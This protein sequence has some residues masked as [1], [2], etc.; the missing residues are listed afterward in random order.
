MELRNLR[1]FIAVAQEL[2][3]GR[4]AAR[5]H[6]SQ[7][8]LSERIKRLEQELGVTLF[9]RTKRSVRITAAGTALFLEAQR[10]L[11]D[12]EGLYQVVRRANEGITGIIRA[13]FMS[14]ASYAGIG[15]ISKRL[16]RQLPGVSITWH[17]M[18]TVE[19]IHALLSMQLD[20]GFIHLPSDVRGL[21]IRPIA[22]DA[23][24]IALSA[25]HPL[26]G[27]KAISLAD[28]R[29]DDFV[30]TPRASNPGL[31]DLIVAA[32]HKAGFSP[33][34]RHQARDLLSIMGLIS[35]NAGV[36]LVPHWLLTAHFPNTI[37]RKLKDKTPLVELGLAWNPEN[38]SPI[39]LR[40]IDELR[41]LFE[42]FQTRRTGHI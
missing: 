1:Y 14:S 33:I 41:P 7:P 26:S 23:L 31:H 6:I 20:L 4:A 35:A 39:L 11:G 9:E 28:L 37:F 36:A 24:M 21:E 3:F 32:C 16:M 15:S 8:P 22:R 12:V 38:R 10:I 13:G 18:P 5:L 17:G 29:D 40:T 27:S 19:Q 30:L 25:S 42:R 34:I 2:H